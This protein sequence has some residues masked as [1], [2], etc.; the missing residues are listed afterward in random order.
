MPPVS[1]AELLERYKALPMP[2]TADEP[3]RF[4]D[5]KGFDPDAYGS[6]ARGSVPEESMLDIDVAG[7][8]V[9]WEDGIE[10]RRAPEGVTFEALDENHERIGTIVGHDEKFAAHNAA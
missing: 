10:I 8:A 1:R 9:V 2:T 4:T 3:W 6:E 5:L 7:L